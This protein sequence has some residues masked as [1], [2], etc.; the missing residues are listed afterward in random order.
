M[1]NLAEDLSNILKSV[2]SGN[3]YY[4]C[5]ITIK[6]VN[7]IKLINFLSALAYLTMYNL[8]LSCLSYMKIYIS[9]Q[10]NK[11]EMLIYRMTGSKPKDYI[12]LQ[13]K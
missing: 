9:C 12:S 7:Q 3:K 8:C 4:Q 11:F 10:H 2:L 5:L 1:P 6:N 13:P